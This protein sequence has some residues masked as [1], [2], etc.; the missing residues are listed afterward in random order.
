MAMIHCIS[1][2]EIVMLEGVTAV[3]KSNVDLFFYVIGAQ[4]ENEVHGEGESVLP[5]LHHLNLFLQLLLFGV[6]NGLYETLSQL[7]K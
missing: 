1:L 6:L 2:A 7:L 4:S 3:Y 5:G